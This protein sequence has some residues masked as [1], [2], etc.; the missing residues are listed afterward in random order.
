MAGLKEFLLEYVPGRAD[1]I[2]FEGFKFLLDLLKEPIKKENTKFDQKLK[3]DI[4]K[5]EADLEADKKRLDNELSIDNIKR[6]EEI[7]QMILDNDIERK[8]KMASL[9]IK[10]REKIASD[11]IKLQNI[12]LTMNSEA[13]QK[14]F[15]LYREELNNFREMEASFDDRFYNSIIKFKD[16]GLGEDYIDKKCRNYLDSKDVREH[17]FWE[18]L[19][20][21]QERLLI[22]ID[23]SMNDFKNIATKYFSPYNRDFNN[24]QIESP[25]ILD[26]N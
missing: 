10:F 23:D 12:L 4:D 17:E 9:E 20:K 22:N 6:R 11:C 2:V 8:E 14:I 3:M 1:D 26:K 13:R 19:L 25:V 24:K 5:F 18:K 7:N 16:I 21:D 15:A